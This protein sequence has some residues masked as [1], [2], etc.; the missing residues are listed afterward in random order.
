MVDLD[1]IKDPLERQALRCQINEFG[2]CP[3][4]LFKI[5]HPPRNYIS[6]MITKDISQISDSQENLQQEQV[7]LNSNYQS[8]WDPALKSQV[9]QKTLPK[10][11]RFQINGILQLSP[12]KIA[13]IGQDGFLKVCDLN[14]L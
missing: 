11:H 7:K 3:K 1:K 12:F 4:Q 8:L 14:T 6:G 5:P 10:A 2:Q 9:K 13:T